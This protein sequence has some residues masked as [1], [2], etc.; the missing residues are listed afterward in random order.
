[1][2]YPL[3]WW[4]A[5]EVMVIGCNAAFI[6]KPWVVPKGQDMCSSLLGLNL[7]LFGAL[8]LAALAMRQAMRE[9]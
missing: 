7:G 5:E 3:A 8:V 2:L 9:S 6:V 4:M 1:M